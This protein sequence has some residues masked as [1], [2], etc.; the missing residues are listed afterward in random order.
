MFFLKGINSTAS[1]AEINV[2]VGLINNKNNNEII[3]RGMKS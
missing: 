3:K 2:M 1:L